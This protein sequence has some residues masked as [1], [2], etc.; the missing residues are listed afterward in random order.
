MTAAVIVLAVIIGALGVGY[1][2]RGG[3]AH[4]DDSLRVDAPCALVIDVK[5]DPKEAP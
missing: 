5:D 4:C 2:V 3:R 1:I